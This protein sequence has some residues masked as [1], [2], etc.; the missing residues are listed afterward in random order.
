MNEA[1]VVGTRRDEAGLAELQQT[2]IAAVLFNTDAA[3][4]ASSTVN[5]DFA[6]ALQSTTHLMVCA[7]P[8]RSEPLDDPVHRVLQKLMAEGLPELA[9]IGYLST[10]GVYGD[11]KGEWVNEDTPCRSAQQRSIVRYQAEQA[12]NAT[13]SALDVPIA[14]LRL[15]GI[16]GPGRNAI[17][18]AQQGRAHMLIKPGQVFNR[19]HVEDLAA[20]AWQAAQ[21]CANG[22]FN[23]TDDEPAPPQDIIRYAHALVGKAAPAELEFA[24]ADISPMARSFYNENKRVSNARSRVLLGYDYRYPDYRQGLNAIWQSVK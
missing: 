16:Y 13:A 6:E 1:R 8:A 18:N 24:T 12:W 22:V 9:W 5:Q 20:A 11:H 7:A 14:I 2:G 10:I 17:L 19:I 4:G 21:Q 23:I 3:S 15:S